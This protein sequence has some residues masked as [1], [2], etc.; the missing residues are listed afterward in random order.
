[1][2]E[3]K[4]VY[5]EQ[6]EVDPRIFSRLY[7]HIAQHRGTADTGVLVDLIWAISLDRSACYFE[8]LERLEPGTRDLGLELLKAKLYGA[9]PPE[10]WEDAHQFAKQLNQPT[11][12]QVSTQNSIVR[13]PI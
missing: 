9:F 1:M 6:H 13:E 10:A 2:S 12:D 11:N 7:S 4:L 5:G 3:R 8:T